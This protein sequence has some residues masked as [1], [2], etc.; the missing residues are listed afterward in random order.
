MEKSG[1]GYKAQQSKL[2]KA[3]ASHDQPSKP[4]PKRCFE[5]GQ[6]GHCAHECEASLPPPLSK[7]ARPSAFNAHYIVRQDKN[8]KVKVSFMGLPN[9]QRPKKI[10]VPKSLVE[11]V[12]GPKQMWVPKT[13]A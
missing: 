13:Q 11:K 8:D 4:K 9:R 1:I 5:F 12:K 2:I 10:W 7:H 3:Q 6:E